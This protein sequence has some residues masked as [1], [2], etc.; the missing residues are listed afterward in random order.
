MNKP[1]SRQPTDLTLEVTINA[2]VVN[3]LTGIIQTMNPTSARQCWAQSHAIWSK[4][5]PHVIEC[6]GIWNVQDVS[7]DL[8]KSNFRRYLYDLES[9]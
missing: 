8:Q 4:L 6:G 1:F 2:G 7:T 3:K 5:R 9:R